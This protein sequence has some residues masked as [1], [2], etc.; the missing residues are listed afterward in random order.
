MNA[1]LLVTAADKGLKQSRTPL[2]PA[3]SIPFEDDE[4]VF[5]LIQVEK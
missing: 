5:T 4:L 1:V 2:V 3:F